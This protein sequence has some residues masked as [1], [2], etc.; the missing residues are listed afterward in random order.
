MFSTNVSLTPALP[1]PCINSH[2]QPPIYEFGDFNFTKRFF[3][4]NDIFSPWNG[5]LDFRLSDVANNYILYC[6]WG[7][8]DYEDASN[9]E[10]DNCVV[11]TDQGA[12]PPSADRRVVTLLSLDQEKLMNRN[13]SL[14]SPIKIAQFWYCDIVN[15]SFP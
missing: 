14:E 9:W 12:V 8:R 5:T 7:Y 15:G 11:I 1:N 2:F 10:N 3:R 13:Q 6:N 4:D